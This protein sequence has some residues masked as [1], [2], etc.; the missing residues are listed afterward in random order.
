MKQLRGHCQCCCRLQAVSNG[1]VAKHGYEVKNRG[2]GGW[3]SGVCSGNQFAPVEVERS[4]LDS[5]VASIR[6]Q[7][8]DM[9]ALADQYKAGT[10]HPAKCRTARYDLAARDY[11]RVNWDAA[12]EWERQDEVTLQVLDLRN[13]A[14]IGEAQASMM[15]R[16]AAARHGKP[17]IE[18]EKVSGPEPI[19]IGEKRT[20]GNGYVATA[21]AVLCGTVY[22]IDGEGFR[23][24]MSTRA[25]RGFPPVS[26]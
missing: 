10:A 5:V 8:A 15:E 16:V 13:R 24:K 6:G 26:V 19:K 23:R 18:V 4:V 25:W 7:I 21:K 14:N 9:R 11:V 20:M 2:Q 12:T 1:Y 22:W 17:L 3:F